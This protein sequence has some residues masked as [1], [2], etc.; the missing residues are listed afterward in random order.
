VI[1]MAL[2]IAVVSQK[3]GVGKTTVSLNLALALAERRRRTLLADLDPQGGIGLSLARADDALAGLADLLMGRSTPQEAV[4]QTKLAALALLPRGRMSAVDIGDYE[5]ALR[6]PGVLA[7]AFAKVETGFELAILDTPSGLGKITRA[8]LALADFAL[9]PVQ[10]EPLALRSIG[11]VLEVI[12]HVRSGENP[13]LEL[14]GLLPTMVQKSAEPSMAVLLEL[15]QG[16]G[17][18]LETVIPRAD[19]FAEASQIGLPVGFL[20]GPPSPEVR[21]FELLAAEVEQAIRRRRGMEGERG[22]Q[23]RRELL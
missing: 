22:T 23:E 8:A 18:V 6:V 16:F 15:W 11:Q 14:L 5:D 2:R 19:V 4:R 3:G 13:K 9:V 7:G 1:E 10:G 20:G 17:A 21:R 12:E